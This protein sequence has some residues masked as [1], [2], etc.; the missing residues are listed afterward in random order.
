MLAAFKARIVPFNVNYRYVAE[1]LLYLLRDAGARGVVY[2]AAF[3]PLLAAVLSQLPEVKLLLQVPDES[4]HALLPGAVEYE[5]AIATA[6]PTRPDLAWSPDDLYCIYTGGTTGMPKGVLWRQ[7]DVFVTALGG[8][9]ADESEWDSLDA[10]V[11]QA[12]R[13]RARGLPTPPFMHGAAHWKGDANILALSGA[14]EPLCDRSKCRS[15][16]EMRVP[17]ALTDHSVATGGA[18]PRRE[19][20]PTS[21]SECWWPLPGTSRA[22]L[23]P[24]VWTGPSPHSAEGRRARR[25]ARVVKHKGTGTGSEA[26]GR[27]PAD[28]SG[29]LC[30]T[31]AVL[32]RVDVAADASWR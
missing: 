30:E 22:Q 21:R 7:A 1:E 31:R 13:G 2:H 10:L 11:A 6:A 5:Q 8:R 32:M 12:A 29:I 23:M 17:R 26:D 9:R 15:T 4:G 20:A 28:T 27:T 18:R 14:I 25:H 19:C 16:I 3:A 24:T